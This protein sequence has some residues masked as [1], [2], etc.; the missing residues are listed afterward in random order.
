M[1]KVISVQLHTFG[2][3]K[4]EKVKLRHKTFKH[5]VNGVR[6]GDMSEQPILAGVIVDTGLRARY[7]DIF[8][9]TTKK[10]G[11][12][13]VVDKKSFEGWVLKEE[14]P[15]F[16][17]SIGMDNDEPINIFNELVWEKALAGVDDPIK[18]VRTR[19]DFEIDEI[20]NEYD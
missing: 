10:V 13:K 2:E 1:E 15:L 14:V 16:R 9:K 4:T 3:E 18:V 11:D 6:N 17:E 7:L 5:S 19:K 20:V 8:C 12:K